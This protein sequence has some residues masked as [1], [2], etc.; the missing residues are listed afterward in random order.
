MGQQQAKRALTIAAAGRHH[1][2]LVG[3]PGVGENTAGQ[4]AA[5]LLP[6]TKQEAVE[7]TTILQRRE[8]GDFRIGAAPTRTAAPPTALP[9]LLSSGAEL[10]PVPVKSPSL[11]AVF[12]S[13]TSSPSSV[14]MPS[15]PSGEPLDQ[16]TSSHR[17]CR[18]QREL[19]GRLLD[20]GHRKSL[21]VR[22]LRQQCAGMPMQ[23]R[24]FSPAINGG[25]G[26][27]FWTGFDM[28]CQLPEVPAAELSQRDPEPWYQNAAAVPWAAN[29]RDI[30]LD[31]NARLMLNRSQGR[32]GPI[33]AELPQKQS[34]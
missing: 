8:A 34:G 19:S 25:C 9:V 6:L 15:K 11:I 16:K 24:R 20:C 7:V 21:P 13:W 28:F 1:I 27:L 14:Q 32:L 29:G 12:G 10:I 26:V 31:P 2:L 4:A 22:L 3:P 30:V 5:S 17:P 23:Q 18:V 33:D